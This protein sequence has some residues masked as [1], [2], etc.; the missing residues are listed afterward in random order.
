MKTT[1]SRSRVFW[2]CTQRP[3]KLSVFVQVGKFLCG[4]VLLTLVTFVS[5]SDASKATLYNRGF[6]HLNSS[7]PVRVKSPQESSSVNSPQFVCIADALC[8]PNFLWSVRPWIYAALQNEILNFKRISRED[9]NAHS[10]ATSSESVFTATYFCTSFLWCFRHRFDPQFRMEHDRCNR[11]GS[12]AIFDRIRNGNT[13]EAPFIDSQISVLD[14][15]RHAYPRPVGQEELS[16]GQIDLTLHSLPLKAHESTLS[17]YFVRLTPNKGQG[18][19]K[20]PYLQRAS[21]YQKKSEE[22][23]SPICPVSST[24]YRHGGKFAD[25]Y[26]MLC[27][28]LC[29]LLSWFVMILGL[30]LFVDR[31]R[32]RLGWSIFGIGVVLAAFACTSGAIG[33]LPWSWWNCLH[34]GCK[35]SQTNNNTQGVFERSHPFCCEDYHQTFA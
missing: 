1:V 6:A 15:P 8:E 12:A 27:I 29:L 14:C 3:S 16:L 23:R 34:D 18:S 4:I 13:S 26:G 5:K 11:G 28:G 10:T 31:G 30:L 2:L 17:F 19:T 9:Q 21:Y 22:P 7:V 20:Q 25:R 24:V 33:C 35:H 32:S